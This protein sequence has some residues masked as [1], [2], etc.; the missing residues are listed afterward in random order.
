MHHKIGICLWVGK[1][2]ALNL[3]HAYLNM[4]ILLTMSLLKAIGTCKVF[5]N[6]S[7]MYYN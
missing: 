7:V 5:K 4:N 3:C 1:K 2:V 6:D